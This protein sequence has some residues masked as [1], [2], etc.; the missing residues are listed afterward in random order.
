LD[1]ASV[2]FLN[3]P[4]KVF[5]DYSKKEVMVSETLKFYEEDFVNPK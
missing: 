3:D 1:E 2:E 5:V 4:K